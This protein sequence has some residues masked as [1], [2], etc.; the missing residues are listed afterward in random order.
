MASRKRIAQI[1]NRREPIDRIS[2]NTAANPAE[3]ETS[4]MRK[5]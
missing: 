1:F 2:L 3:F 5:V 4:R